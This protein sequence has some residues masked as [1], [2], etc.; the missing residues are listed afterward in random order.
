MQ[1]CRHQL[2]ATNAVPATDKLAPWFAARP[3]HLELERE[4][5]KR[6]LGEA[7]I[8]LAQ[9][10]VDHAEHKGCSSQRRNGACGGGAGIENDE[11]APQPMSAMSTTVLTW[12]MLSAEE[13][14][15]QSNA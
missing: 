6:L 15:E 7:V 4:N 1:R 3:F 10:P 2:P 8:T 14:R 12:M 9:Q 11:F 5:S 13:Q